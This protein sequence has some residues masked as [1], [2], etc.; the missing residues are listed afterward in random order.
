MITS[1]GEH[2]HDAWSHHRKIMT[3]DRIIIIEREREHGAWSHLRN[4]MTRGCIIEREHD[5]WS[6]H[7][8]LLVVP[9]RI[10]TSPTDSPRARA[11]P[12]ARSAYTAV[13]TAPRNVIMTQCDA[14]G[15]DGGEHCAMQ[16]HYG[17]M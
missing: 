10:Q 7:R 14:L 1:S 6:H 9:T 13:D 5:M 8:N 17:M 3:H 2:E 11:P 12:A 16:G 4:I 15:L